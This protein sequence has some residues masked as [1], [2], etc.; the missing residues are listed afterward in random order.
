M[1]NERNQL[2]LRVSSR[3]ISCRWL[4]TLPYPHSR[5]FRDVGLATTI[6]LASSRSAVQ[7][8]RRKK[9]APFNVRRRL[10]RLLVG[11]SGIQCALNG[12]VQQSSEAP[13]RRMEFG[14]NHAA[15]IKAV[16][17]SRARCGARCAA[18]RTSSTLSE[19][20]N[21]LQQRSEIAN[22][23]T[24]ALA[25]VSTQAPVKTRYIRLMPSCTGCT[26]IW[27]L[28]TPIRGAPLPQATLGAGLSQAENRQSC[29]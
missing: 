14:K 17:Y 18:R 11:S 19:S 22:R 16:G 21:V 8:S 4:R 26:R 20:T 1:V 15:S 29:S 10:G 7:S 2:I 24:E 13:L 3:I 25:V 23:S 28:L 12:H 5:D 9:W 27:R 6:Q